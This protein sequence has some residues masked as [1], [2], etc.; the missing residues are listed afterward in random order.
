MLDCTNRISHSCF[1]CSQF[2]SSLPLLLSIQTCANIFFSCSKQLKGKLA[3]S[4][5]SQLYLNW[6]LPGSKELWCNITHQQF[7][8][9]IIKKKLETRMTAKNTLTVQRNTKLIW[10]QNTAQNVLHCHTKLISTFSPVCA[11]SSNGIRMYVCGIV[12]NELYGYM[13]K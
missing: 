2:V 4:I 11:Q 8:L 5:T 12:W 7:I 10:L 1:L 13:P 9:Y 3:K 6:T